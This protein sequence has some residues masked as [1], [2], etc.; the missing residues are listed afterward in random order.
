MTT[1]DLVS[2]GKI[3]AAFGIQGWVKIKTG[4]DHDSLKHY[5]ALHILNGDVDKVLKIEKSFVKNDIWFVLFSGKN[6]RNDAEALIGSTVAISR[7][8]FPETAEDEYYWVD[9]IGHQV[10]NQQQ[11]VLGI[12]DSLMET[13]ATSVLVVQG[14][15]KK[16]LIPFVAAYVINV[17]M[18]NKRIIVDWGLDY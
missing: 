14:S 4:S 1:S 9:L 17:D 3:V 7:K 13:G 16:H 2:M 18:Q 6:S 12:V 8:D 10:I 5:N 11:Q 15:E